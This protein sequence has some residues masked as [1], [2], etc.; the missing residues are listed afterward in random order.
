MRMLSICAAL[1]AASGVAHAEG[2]F[3]WFG[4]VGA[5]S[6]YRWRGISLTGNDPAVQAGVTVAHESGFYAGAWGAAPTRKSGA[7]DIDLY[8]GYYFSALGGD[9]DLSVISYVFPDL[10]DTD[11]TT[12]VATYARVVGPATLRA[13]AEYAPMQ[14]NLADESVYLAA[15]TEWALGDTGV[16]ALASVGWEEGYFTLDGEKWDYAVG[17]QYEVGPVVLALS[18]VGSD[19]DAPLGEEDTYQGGFVFSIKANL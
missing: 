13:R 18:Y 19:E 6:D 3:D 11:Y 7:V 8:G 5:V 14:D 16:V 10:D 12:G 15:E 2:S 9:F 4:E 1:T 17:A